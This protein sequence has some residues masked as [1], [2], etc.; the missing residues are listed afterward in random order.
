M[1]RMPIESRACAQAK[2]KD[3]LVKELMTHMMEKRDLNKDGKIDY[4]EL[5]KAVNDEGALKKHLGTGMTT[6][7]AIDSMFA[8]KAKS[9]VCVVM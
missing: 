3:A 5:L 4:N 2:N 8:G 7:L 1:H 9:S 6:A